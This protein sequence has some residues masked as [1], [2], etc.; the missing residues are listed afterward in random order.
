MQ[1]N[2]LDFSRDFLKLLNKKTDMLIRTDP[3]NN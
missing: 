3:I 2:E 1:L